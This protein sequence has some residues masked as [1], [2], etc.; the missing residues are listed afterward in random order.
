M[1]RLRI[2]QYFQIQDY[3]QWDVI[4]NGNSFKP[5]A[6]RTTDDAGTSTTII[7]S[8]V[9]IKE[10]AKKKND[11]KA[12]NML[13]MALPNEHLMT[14]NQYK[15]AKTLFAVIETRFSRNEST[16]KTQKTLL[17]QLYENFSATG[18]ESLDSISNRFLRSLPSEWNTHVVVWRNKSDLDTM[19]L[20]DLYN[21]F[22]IVE[23]E[24]RGTTS[25]NTSS[26]NMTFISSPS[27]NS[28][29]EVPTDFEVST[30]SPQVSTANLSNATMYAF[31]ANQP[32]GSQLMHED[33]EQ[34][35]EDDLEEID[36]KWQLALLSMRAKR[37]FQKTG[38]KIT[39]NGSDAASYDK[40][41]V[42]CF[43]YHKTVNVEDTS[44]KAMV[45]IDGA[46]FDWSYMADDEAPTNMAFMALSGSEKFE[47][48]SQSLEKLIGIQVTDNSKKGLGY[49]SYN[50]VPPPHT[51][52]F[53]P[54]RIDLAY[55]GLPEF[56]EPSIQT[57]EVKPIELD[58]ESDEEGEVESPPKK[59]RNTVESSMDKV[60][61]EISKQNDKPARRPVKYAEM[62]RTQ[63]PRGNKK[64]WNNLK[65][66]QLGNISYLTDF[67]EFDGGYVTF[68]GEAKGGKITK[69]GTIRNGK[70]D[71]EDVYFVKQLQFKLFS[72]SQMCDKKNSVLFTD[73]ECIVLSTDFKLATKSHVLLKVP[74][75]N[76]MYSVDMKNIIPK[77]DLTCLVAK[78]TNDESMLWHRRLGHINFKNINKLV[79][80]NLNKVLVVKPH[81][82]TPYEPFR[83]RTPALSFMRP[84]RCYVTILN[85]LDHLGK[86]NGKSNEGFFVGYSTNS[87][88]FRVYNTRT[89]KLFD[90]DTLT[91]SMNYVPVIAGTT[92]NDFAGK[93]A[94]FDA[95]QSSMEIRLNQDYILMPLWNDD[96]LFDSSPKALDGDNQ[97]NDG[98]NAE[99]END[100]QERPNVEHNTKDSNTVRPSINNAVQILILLVQQLILLGY[101]WTLVDLP[102][103]KRAI[104]TKWVFRNKKG[105]RGIVIRNKARLVA[106][107]CTQEEGIDYD[108]AF[109][110]VMDV[111]SAFLYRRIEEEVY[112]CQPL[113]FEDPDY[114]DKVYKVKKALYGNRGK[115]W[116]DGGGEGSC[117]VRGV[118]VVRLWWW[119][120]GVEDCCNGGGSGVEWCRGGG[121]GVKGGGGCGGVI[122]GGGGAGKI[123]QTLFIKRQ[124][125]DILLVQVYV[126][127]IIFGSTKK[128]LCTEFEVLMHDNF[129]MS[130]MGELTFFIGLQV[131]QKSD[132]IFIS[133][134]KYV[135][136][137]LRKFKYDDVKPANTLMDKEKALLKD[138][139][140]DDVDVHLYRSMIRCLMYLTSSRPDIMFAVCTYA[141]FQVTP[142]VAHLHAVK[143]IFKYLKGHPKLG[144]W[145]PRDSLFDLVA[146]TDSDYARASLNR[147]STSRGCQFLGY[148]LI[149]WHCK[150][151]TVVATSTTKAEYVAA[152]SCCG[153]KPQGSKDFHQIVD[154]LKASHISVK[155]LD[156]GEIELNA[157][158]DGHNKTITE[159]SVKRHLKLADADG[160]STL[161]PTEIFEQL[162]LMGYV[163]DSDKLTFQKDH[164]F[165][166]WG[167]LI[168]TILHCLSP[169]KTSWEQ[170]SSNI[171]IAI[172][173]LATNRRFNFSK[174]IFDGMV[175]NLENKYKFM[176]Y[177]R[178]LQMILNK[179]TRINTSHKRLYIAPSLTQK[180]F[181]NMKRKSRGFS[182]VET[183]L[184]PTMLV[185]EQVS[186][187]EGPTSPVGTQYTPTII[188][189]S[190]HLQNISITYRKTETKTRRMGIKIPQ[191]IVPLS[192]ED[193]AITKER[194]NGLRRATTTVS[195]LAAEQG[196]CNI[197]K[198]QTK[199]TPSGE[200][201]SRTILNGGPECHFT[202]G[203]SPVQVRPERLSNLPNEPP[204]GK[205]EK[206]ASLDHEDSPKQERIIEEIDKDKN[207]NLVKISEQGEAHK[208][209]KHKMDLST[210]NQM[211][212]DETVT[213]ALLNIKRSASK[214][215]GKAIMQ[216]S[217]SPKKIKK[218]KMMQ[219][220]LDEEIAQRFYEEEQAQ[221]L[222][223]KNMLNKFKIN[224]LLMKQD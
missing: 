52:R 160:I 205:E 38:K 186:Y 130:S 56:A 152:A 222:R 20:D 192:A 214:D 116:R 5:V 87:K 151:Q 78:A 164:F 37:F 138:S 67:K 213:E 61:V 129:R 44:S 28:T 142:K 168:H 17:K 3:A 101:V 77:K 210:A 90:M 136:E 133:Q 155:T 148:R 196:S 42:E 1:W 218:K 159:A 195:S 147:K 183:T 106:Q 23:Q 131:K 157:T 107:G 58:W 189:S 51:R 92:S 21:N 103:G 30:A 9:T 83:G 201:S 174:L 166:Q 121:C 143:R 209:T 74:R 94:S 55:T 98:P 197:P 139:D 167:F 99:S 134:D 69:K 172:I 216:E 118:V 141:K 72:V 91:E 223:M 45:A 100:N 12:R 185:T 18:T 10:K 175:K 165:P 173:C 8:P 161:P 11:V 154:F 145:Y 153:Q 199:E 25:T 16:K 117:G 24:I 137:I 198:T 26:Q 144:L 122:D 93:G 29:N 48:A 120:F 119:S 104:G 212:D 71:F 179:D 60:G 47:N 112:V 217:V 125:E 140:G 171:A 80:D 13:L 68:G 123:D 84:F 63:T 35:Y 59:E 200:S 128:E 53:L 34:I 207:V 202:M 190:P 6:E 215:N 219:I 102:R 49:V 22:K 206:E 178:F 135:D 150:K 73:T 220:S 181:S 188:E 187:G 194:P 184:F 14:F 105:K 54:P 40:S 39:I 170:F 169:K 208:T 191:S 162:A 193:E 114:P 82:K 108:D 211:D 146:Y 2:E 158:I 32:N 115:G 163:I 97:D 149:S 180:V 177:L 85:T 46:G 126:D 113:G 70:L 221:I 132:G 27:P 41:K 110:P 7:P 182:R 95:G 64:N 31:L 36:L 176:M 76:N 65:S 86:F 224:R 15:D 109:P 96:S 66:H 19:S 203:D 57:Y 62:Y 111:K 89:R 4:E 88:A 127:D 156:N 50:V 33:L 204:L 43:N 124:K 79:K 75:K 81:V